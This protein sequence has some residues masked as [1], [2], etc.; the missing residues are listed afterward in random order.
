M[1]DTLHLGHSYH[2]DALS[3]HGVWIMNNSP[4][5]H[6]HCLGPSYSLFTISS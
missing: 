4:S 1:F 2:D 6:L 3:E 5:T